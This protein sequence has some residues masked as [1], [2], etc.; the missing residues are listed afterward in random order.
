MTPSDAQSS[1]AKVLVSD[2]LSE[3]GLQ[4][5]RDAGL[6]VH[7]NTGLSEDQLA[8]IIDGY[9][10]LIIRSAT[11]VT[12][13]VISAASKL[14][15]IGRAGVG[16]DNIDVDAA[17]RR[18]IVVMN[19]PLGNI[20]SAAEHTIALLMAMARNVSAA[21]NA[22]KAGRWEKKKFTGVEL[23]GKILGIIG[24][25][26]V[27][28][29]VA[30][31]AQG[32]GMRTL[33]HD[34]FLPERRA[35]ELNVE[36]GE[37]DDVLTQADFL[38]IHTPLNDRTR[39][40]I[41]AEALAKMK[42]TAR[43]INCAR[44]GIVD[45]N[46][47]VHALESGAIAGAAMDVFAQEPLPPDSPLRT[48]PN[49]ILTPHLGASTEE[50]QLKVAEAIARQVVAFFIEGK[51][52]N[53]INLGVTLTPEIKPFADLA[54]TMGRF[55]SQMLGAPP[56]SLRCLARGKL[57]SGDIQPLTVSALQ[58]LLMT[59]HDHPVNIVNAPLVA[60]ER[61]LTVTEEKSLTSPD[62]ANLFRIE[63]KTE[64]RLHSIAGTVFEGRQVRIV[65]IDG[66]K[67]DLKPG[68][69]VLVMFYP[70]RPGMVGKFGTI[71]GNANINIAGMDVAREKKH[72]RACVVLAVDDPVP[73]D[74][75]EEIRKA[76]G[77]GEAFLV[78]T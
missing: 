28:R 8:A 15:V 76:T 77:G 38:T 60:E 10:A 75:L 25:G 62:Y 30:R 57:A 39:G 78:E 70:D 18:G 35:R 68:G 37:L 49:I 61:G 22:L 69:P 32:L 5:M 12:P 67:L 24:M 13:R 9:D 47:L 58:G 26:K 42:P 40:M 55:V 74:I 3:I 19:T 17:S 41:N 1:A 59:W 45:E 72:G 29:I 4:T 21:D 73:E 64:K 56:V 52:E 51:I 50:A 71:L 31:A 33:A 27:G 34:P 66:F 53:A 11:K 48:A 6:V 43:L 44:G 2:A 23:N 14:K 7:A 54:R 63:V 36:L 65:E 16:V 46:A 20:T